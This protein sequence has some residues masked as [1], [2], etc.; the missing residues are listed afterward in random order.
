MEK[1]AN[2]D[3]LVK[4]I[5]KGISRRTVLLKGVGGLVSLFG[6]SQIAA[7]CANFAN[8]SSIATTEHF[9]V[10]G[11]TKE[12]AEEA[13]KSLEDLTGFLGQ[14]Y[15]G[16][17]NIQ[18]TGGGRY[19]TA[20][21]EAGIPPTIYFA[22]YK[23]SSGEDAKVHEITHAIVQ[24]TEPWNEGLATV[25]QQV[26]RPR[27]RVPPT[28]GADLHLSVPSKGLPTDMELVPGGGFEQLLLR[29]SF[30]G[31]LIEKYGIERLMD[32]NSMI[33]YTPERGQVGLPKRELIVYNKSYDELL[34]EWVGAVQKNPKRTPL[35]IN[36]KPQKRIHNEE[37]QKKFG[38]KIVVIES[39]NISKSGLREIERDGAEAY[40]FL[41]TFFGIQPRLINGAK[42]RIDATR[43][44]AHYQYDGKNYNIIQPYAR[45]VSNRY[46]LISLMA[47]PF[48]G[49]KRA[50]Q[51]LP[52]Q[53][54]A[55]YLEALHP[56]LGGL[57]NRAPPHYGVDIDKLVKA[58]IAD[59]MPLRK[60]QF[61]FPESDFK[62]EEYKAHILP[63]AQ[64]GSF[65]KYVV[66]QYTK[67][68]AKKGVEMLLKAAEGNSYE[69]VF[70][71][72]L[73]VM[74]RGWLQ[75]LR[76]RDFR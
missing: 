42:I 72:S 53:A 38:G 15:Y 17:I 75:S 74:E 61:P 63:F 2:L 70:G 68:D 62:G 55:I 76:T 45:A 37:I 41:S 24:S 31:Y 66:N 39:E 28:Y 14:P 25:T 54:T 56:T 21:T 65:A 33:Y 20:Y 43:D 27:E 71:A 59:L 29:G 34:N 1:Q 8:P 48:I 19:R 5:D 18:V 58:H 7:T 16:I 44:E 4:S 3:L 67:G 51:I 10:Y 9:R 50:V 69:S 32:F 6:L 49:P 23:I 26:L 30:V 35:Q 52:R 36:F 73:D 64:A 11:G 60:L 13:E 40:N 57:K 47:L 12:Y 22:N 46:S